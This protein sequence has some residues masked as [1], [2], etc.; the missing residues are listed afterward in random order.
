MELFKDKVVRVKPCELTIGLDDDD[1]T[2]SL[3]SVE[4]QKNLK[5]K[6]Y[7]VEFWTQRWLEYRQSWLLQKFRMLKQNNKLGDDHAIT[8][9]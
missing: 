4:R 7:K 6:T 3:K 8:C 5:M 1:L 9:S 2:L